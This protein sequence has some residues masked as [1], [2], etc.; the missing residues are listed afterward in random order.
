MLTTLRKDSGMPN[1]KIVFVKLNNFNCGPYWNEVRRQQDLVRL[2]NTIKIDI[3]DIPGEFS[4]ECVHFKP[5]TDA[6]RMV[7]ER[8]A[9]SFIS[10]E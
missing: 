9:E 10:A 8:M 4:A 7:A 1:L 6:Y 2:S 5:T 3:D